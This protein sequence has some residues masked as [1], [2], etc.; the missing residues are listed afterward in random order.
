MC[1]DWEGTLCG[2]W[3]GTLCGDWDGTLC[4]DWEGTLCGDWEGTLCGDWEGTLCG[5][6]EG[7]LCDYG[8]VDTSHFSGFGV[9]YM[10]PVYTLV[11]WKCK[12]DA[13]MGPQVWISCHGD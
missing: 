8:N 7:T 2:D 9:M 4:G 12:E 1:G 3:E 10:L 11:E 5:D 13:S 6:W